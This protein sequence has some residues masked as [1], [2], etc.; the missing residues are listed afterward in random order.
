MNLEPKEAEL[1]ADK[2]RHSEQIAQSEDEVARCNGEL[3]DVREN[4]LR[5]RREMDGLSDV[6]FAREEDEAIIEDSSHIP[7]D[8]DGQKDS[9]AKRAWDERAKHLKQVR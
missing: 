1:K 9:A 4:Q 7:A 3:N 6:L 8:G 2:L 5:L